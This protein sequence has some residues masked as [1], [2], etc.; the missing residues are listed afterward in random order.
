MWFVYI[1]ISALFSSAA[2]VFVKLGVKDVDTTLATLIK[3]VVVVLIAWTVVFAGGT[4]PQIAQISRRTMTFLVLSG[5]TTGGSW[6]CDYSALKL[7]D[8]D[9]AIAVSRC[10]MVLSVVLAFLFLGDPFTVWS[11]VGTLLILGGSLLMIDPKHRNSRQ[12]LSRPWLLWVTGGILFSSTTTILG[13][14]GISGV[15]SNLGTAIHSLVVLIMTCAMVGTS[16]KWKQIKGIPRQKMV[17]LL[18]SGAASAITWLTYYRGLQLQYA[19]I[20][21]PTD[22]LLSGV[23]TALMAYFVFQEQVDRRAALALGCIGAGTVIIVL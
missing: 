14:V 21:A 8:V 16:G 1:F 9:T 18:L 3:T 11:L 5:L 10:S 22:K 4:T 2:T 13:K 23:L 12:P 17:C 6:I 7:G 19:S 15:N 20:V